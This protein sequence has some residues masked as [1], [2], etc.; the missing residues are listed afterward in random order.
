MTQSEYGSES[1]LD[2]RLC[3]HAEHVTC[4]KDHA[5]T[6]Y[7]VHGRYTRGVNLLYAG[8]AWGSKSCFLMLEVQQSIIISQTYRRL[9]TT[10][11]S[12][13]ML[14]TKSFQ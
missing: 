12:T 10:V 3:N 7:R 9:S 5:T 4:L 1:K 2:M 13:T 14:V 8:N 11:T 6:M